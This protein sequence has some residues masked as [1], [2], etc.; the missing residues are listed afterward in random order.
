MESK[1]NTGNRAYRKSLTSLGQIF[2]GEQEYGIRMLNLSLTG[3]LAELK[4]DANLHNVKDLSDAMKVSSVIDVYF[5][6][7]GMTG[8]AEIARFTSINSGFQIGM[9]FRNIA[10][11]IDDLMYRSRAYRKKFAALGRIEFN[12]RDYAFMTENASVSGLMISMPEQLEIAT[13]QVTRIEFEQLN[14]HADVE[15]I[16]VKVKMTSTLIGLRYLK[17]DSDIKAIPKFGVC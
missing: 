4:Y 16:W 10:Y 8:E 6:E 5:P 14:I 17:I 2:L 1:T 9:E 15:V 7:M 13:G 3:V 12:G 11:E